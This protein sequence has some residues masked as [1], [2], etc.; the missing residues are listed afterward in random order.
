[1]RISIFSMI[2]ILPDR[3]CS[4]DNSYVMIFDSSMMP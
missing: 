2:S 1:L 4:L 3:F